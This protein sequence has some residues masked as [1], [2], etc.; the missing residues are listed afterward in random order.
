MRAIG[1]CSISGSSAEPRAEGAEGMASGAVD[2]RRGLVA[3]GVAADTGAAPCVTAAAWLL[4]SVP[5]L[6]GWSS[7][8]FLHAAPSP[9]VDRDAPVALGSYTMTRAQV[10]EA[11]A[12][13][14]PPPIP[15]SMG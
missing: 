9:V 14:P 7:T 8:F 6:D 1:S 12:A 13:T 2:I 15:D 4:R 10:P 11:H 5:P 3:A